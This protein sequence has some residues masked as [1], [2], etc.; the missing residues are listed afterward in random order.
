MPCRTLSIDVLELHAA[1]LEQA[2]Y[3]CPLAQREAKPPGS[4]FEAGNEIDKRPCIS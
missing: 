4:R 1:G 3:S 2:Q